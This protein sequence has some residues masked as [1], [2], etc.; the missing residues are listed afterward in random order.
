M[1]FFKKVLSNFK[2]QEIKY[3]SIYTIETVLG[4]NLSCV[5]CA[6]GSNI[7]NREKQM[8]SFE[9][10]KIIADKIKPYAKYVY[11]H[12]WGEPLLNKDIFKMIEYTSKFA[13][14]NISTNGMLVNQEMAENLIKSGVSDIIVSIDGVTQEVYKKYRRNGDVEK[15]KQ[16]LKYIIDAKNKF[17]SD[18]KI[19]P[20]F[21]VF[22]HN[23]HEME[24]FKQFCSDVSEGSIVP[25][26][27]APYIRKNSSLKLSSLNEYIRKPFSSDKELEKAILNCR[28]FFDV[29]TIDVEG[30]VIVCCYDHN[31]EIVFGNIFKQ[32]LEEIFNGTIRKNFI[33][34]IKNDKIC[35]EFCKKNCLLYTQ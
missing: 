11:L 31:S 28:D 18:V 17:N 9:N 4:C 5:E 6:I 10:F 1:N 25:V 8:M 15:A 26:F 32:S 30:N 19:F 7:V 27:K 21:I 23:Q 24:A 14:T 3:P 16:A 2:K 34:K 13:K 12:S 29:F 20:Q 35:P 22:E 33:R